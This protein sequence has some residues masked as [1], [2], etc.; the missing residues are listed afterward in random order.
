MGVVARLVRPLDQ[1]Q[2]NACAR[3]IGEKRQLLEIAA[4][5]GATYM[6]D[7]R[8]AGYGRLEPDGLLL[9][10]VHKEGLVTGGGCLEHFES[11]DTFVWSLQEGT[12]PCAM[13]LAGPMLELRT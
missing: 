7:I 4:M 8:R 10:T 1:A 11:D 6:G 5:Y 2:I 3:V 13:P 12:D 9:V